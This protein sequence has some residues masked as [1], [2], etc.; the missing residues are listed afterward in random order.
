MFERRGLSISMGNASPEVRRVDVVTGSNGEDSFAN[1]V[2]R[3]ILAAVF[4]RARWH[5]SSRGPR[6]VEPARAASKIS[7]IR[8]AFSR[9]NGHGRDRA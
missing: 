6:M 7:L 5:R 1:A 8:Q 4:E 2:E 9:N 3:F